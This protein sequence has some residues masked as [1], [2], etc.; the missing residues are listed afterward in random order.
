M[1]RQSSTHERINVMRYS[2]SAGIDLVHLQIRQLRQASC[3]SILT[4]SSSSNIFS[5]PNSRLVKLM[6][7]R[8]V[9]GF[10]F[11]VLKLDNEPAKIHSM[12]WYAREGVHGGADRPA[13]IFVSMRTQ[14]ARIGKVPFLALLPPSLSL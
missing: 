12:P 7:V 14:R 9:I 10:A 4:D 11:A 8:L 5:D 6:L 3:H 1:S 13:R 2:S